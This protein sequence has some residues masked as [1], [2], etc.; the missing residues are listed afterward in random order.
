[1]QANFVTELG[2][3]AQVPIISFSASSPLLIQRSYFLR[4]AQNDTCQVKAISAII[5]A[6]GWNEAVPISVNDEF[7]KGVIPYLTTALQAVGARIPYWVVIPSVA[8]DD[9]IDAELDRLMKMQ[10]RVFIVHMLPSL[11][12]RLFAR[13]N[14]RGMMEQ[15]F[16][17]IVTN[18]MSNFFSSSNYSVMDNMQGVLGLKTYVP[19]T[20]QLENFRGRWQSIFQH[21]NPTLLNVKLNVFGLWAYDAAWALATAVETTNFPSRSMNISAG[22]DSTCLQRLKVSQSGPELVR[23]LSGTRFTGLSGDF[24]LIN[25]Q[26][27]SSTFQ[28][29]NVN[30]NGERGVGYWTPQNGLVKNLKSKNISRYAANS[31]ASLGTIIWPGDT[32]S[33]PKGWQIP[34]K[35]KILVP[36]TRNTFVNVIYDHSTN[37]TNVAG[38]CIDVFKAVIESLPYPVPY[39]FYPFAISGGSTGRYNDLVNQV[40][41]GVNSYSELNFLFLIL[42]LYNYLFFFSSPF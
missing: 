21:D 1:M 37:S 2:E 9:Q 7:G 13:A 3:K 27:Q 33:V 31:N 34:T 28:V 12:S 38:Y 32:T 25:G 11:G 22:A 42:S 30:D 17:W 20:E 15:G 10:T 26:L 40:F 39:E 35:L 23:K 4:I 29:V 6:F 24:I 16:A 19:N 18:G 14:A 36:T 41:L 5:Q 8:T